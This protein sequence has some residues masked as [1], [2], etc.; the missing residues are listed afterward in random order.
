MLVRNLRG[1]NKE[2]KNNLFSDD[3]KSLFLGMVAFN[4]QER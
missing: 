1:I 4:P 2:I 3:F